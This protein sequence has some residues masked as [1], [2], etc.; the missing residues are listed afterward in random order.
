MGRESSHSFATARPQQRASQKSDE[1]C[2]DRE[3]GD[4]RPSSMDKRG[5]RSW[6]S[7]QAF[8]GGAEASDCLF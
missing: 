8:S 7:G 3:C 2:H 1:S 4:T 6:T 5:K